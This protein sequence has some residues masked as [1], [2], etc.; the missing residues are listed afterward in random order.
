[1]LTT[2]EYKVTAKVLIITPRIAREMLD[3]NDKNR[4]VDK[5]KVI[6]YAREIEAGRWAFNGETIIVSETGRLLNGQHRLLGCIQ[7]DESFPTLVVF[8]LP[9]D[10]FLT[11]DTGKKRSVGDVLSMEGIPYAAKIAAAATM[12]MTLEDGYSQF[13]G[14]RGYTTTEVTDWVNDHPDLLD[15]AFSATGNMVIVAPSICMA[16]HY[17]FARKDRAAADKFMLDLYGGV[18]LTAGDPV[19]VLREALIRERAAKARSPRAERVA[20]IINAWNMRRRGKTARRIIGTM[21]S[22]KTGERTFPKVV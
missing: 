2:T 16:T 3:A 8:G 21:R 22:P 1:M 7:A 14:G 4:P 19:L 20:M 13:S 10:V 17:L 6:Q 11:I 15:S 18:G 12:L 5:K 9:N